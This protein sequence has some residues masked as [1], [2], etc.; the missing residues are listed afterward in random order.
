MNAVNITKNKEII[1]KTGR[2]VQLHFF[3]FV[4]IHSFSY[5]DQS[6]IVIIDH[7]NFTLRLKKGKYN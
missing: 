3:F 6:A 2:Q 7:N 5:I 1:I 4:K